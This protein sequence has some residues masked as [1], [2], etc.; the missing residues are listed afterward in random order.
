MLD[1]EDEPMTS[2]PVD[3]PDGAADKLCATARAPPQD[4]QGAPKEAIRHLQAPADADANV[5][6]KRIDGLDADRID[7]SIDVDSPEHGVTN[8]QLDDSTSS[9]GFP[10]EADH[11]SCVPHS[12][13]A[14]HAKPATDVTPSEQEAVPPK[15][16]GDDPMDADCEMTSVPDA[17][18]TTFTDDTMR[19]PESTNHGHRAEVTS[20]H[21]QARSVGVHEA[22]LAPSVAVEEAASCRGSNDD[23]INERNRAKTALCEDFNEPVGSRDENKGTGAQHESTSS[24][25]DAAFD[26]V[27]HAVVQ[28]PDLQTPHD[29]SSERN[30]AENTVCVGLPIARLT[31]YM[32]AR[33]PCKMWMAEPMSTMAAQVQ[34]TKATSKQPPRVLM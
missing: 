8:T 11:S 25:D 7:A 24:S 33:C 3:V 26:G 4:T 5:I 2:S 31:T 16:V 17:E 15:I 27:S 23:C 1:S 21:S 18:I 30:V 10:R 29:A 34:T 13:S 20:E 19:D 9:Q 32:P 28:G 6:A 14:L 12:N 22:K